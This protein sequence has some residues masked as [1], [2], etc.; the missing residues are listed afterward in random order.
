MAAQPVSVD[1]HAGRILLGAAKNFSVR[2]GE[3]HSIRLIKPLTRSGSWLIGFRGQVLRAHSTLALQRGAS[4][5]VLTTIENGRLFLKIAD[6]AGPGG[7]AADARI[8][9]ELRPLTVL[10]RELGTQSAIPGSLQHTRELA[11]QL[12]RRPQGAQRQQLLAGIRQLYERGIAPEDSDA[13]IAFAETHERGGRP[14][15]QHHGGAPAGGG[16]EQRKRKDKKTQTE[17]DAADRIENTDALHA[18]YTLTNHLKSNKDGGQHWIT[19][20]FSMRVP[21]GAAPPDAAAGQDGTQETAAPPSDI[22]GAIRLRFEDSAQRCTEAVVNVVLDGGS[23]W[24]IYIHPLQGT[25]RRVMVGSD[26]SA[27]PAIMQT[28]IPQL[29]QR[30]ARWGIADISAIPIGDEEKAAGAGAGGA[31]D[32]AA[33]RHV[34]VKA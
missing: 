5:R 4:L 3:Y 18:L 7:G 11:Q 6:A 27:M 17:T 31:D 23:V 24:R 34:N 25:G 14:P 28:V 33:L 13:V 21:T 29:S 2:N 20:P 19:L 26:D 9:A 12:Q 15:A 10:L 30:L 32:S 22:E 16:N 8:A 1:A